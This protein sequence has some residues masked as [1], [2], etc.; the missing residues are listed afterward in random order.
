[1]RKLLFIVALITGCNS[2]TF[3][4]IP[5][6]VNTSSLL[7][8]LSIIDE[9]KV[10]ASGTNGTVIRSLDGGNSWDVF[11]HPTADTLQFRDIHAFNKDNALVMSIGSGPSSQ[12]LL[13]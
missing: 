1:M 12:I 4:L 13:Y 10:W 5:Q 6:T 3:E 9:T 2:P 8:G 7:I 11:V